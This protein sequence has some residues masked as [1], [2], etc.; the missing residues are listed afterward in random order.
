MRHVVIIV[1]SKSDIKQCRLGL[2]WLKANGD[3]ITVNAFHVASQHRHT[4]RVQEILTELANSKNPPDAI[5][6][7]AGWANHLTGC[8]DAFLRYKL[9]DTMIHVIGVAFMDVVQNNQ[10]EINLHENHSLAAV[11][12]ITCVPGTQVIFK[13]DNGKEFIGE[14]G[15]LRACKFAAIGIFPAITL[16][17]PPESLEMSLEKALAEAKKM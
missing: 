3:K 16:K 4:L 5:I 6:V 2:E 14:E 10:A 15:L 1:G 17:E 12:S 7:G 13:D 8:C 9:K 11:L